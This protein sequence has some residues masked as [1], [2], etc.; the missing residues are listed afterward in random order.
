MRKFTKEWLIASNDDLL[1]I[2]EI[3]ELEHL[4]HIVAFH[5]QQSV[6]KSLKA[7]IEEYEIDVPKIHKLSKL[8]NMRRS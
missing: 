1:T 3:K 5:A 8:H 2:Y 7:L 4:T 6:E